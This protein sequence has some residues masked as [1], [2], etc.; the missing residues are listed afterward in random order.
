[1]GSPSWASRAMMRAHLRRYGALD[2]RLNVQKVRLAGCLRAPPRSWTLLLALAALLRQAPR[3][4]RRAHLRRYGA[5]DSRLN[6]QKV[7][8][9]GCLRA[10]PRSWALLIALGACR[11]DFSEEARRDHQCASSAMPKR[12]TTAARPR[13][14]PGYVPGRW[15]VGEWAGPSRRRGRPPR[16]KQPQQIVGQQISCHSARTLATP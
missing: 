3:A 7:R 2:S 4:T 5:L 8:L 1:M 11:S 13:L 15:W 12:G 16:A 14:R 9:A 6:V 10:P